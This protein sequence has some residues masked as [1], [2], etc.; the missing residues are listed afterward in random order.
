MTLQHL[1]DCHQ[2]H[3]L[4]ISS[5]HQTSYNHK[6]PI[7]ILDLCSH[8]HFWKVRMISKTDESPQILIGPVIVKLNLH[9]LEN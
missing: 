7:Q 2:V 1:V 4:G 9:F 5:H 6:Y 3:S 8:C